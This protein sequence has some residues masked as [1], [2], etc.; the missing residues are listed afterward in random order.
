MP[1]D[2]PAAHASF[3][4]VDQAPDGDGSQRLR[5]FW[6]AGSRESGED[7]QILTS[8][9]SASPASPSAADVWRASAVAVNRHAAYKALGLWNLGNSIRRLGNPV[10]WVDAQGR[11][12]LYVVATTWLGGWAAAR[13][14]HLR[15][16]QPATVQPARAA[17]APTPAPDF[18]PVGF[19][20]LSPLFNI[21]HLVRGAP[22]DLQDGGALLPAYFEL[23]VKYPVAIRLDP[24]GNLAP[25]RS[26][27]VR[28]AGHLQA[29]QPSVAVTSSQE[30]VAYLRDGSGAQTLGVVQTKDAGQHWQN[31]TTQAAQTSA[32]VGGQHTADALINPDSSVCALSLAGAQTLLVHN[33]QRTGRHRL[34]IDASLDGRH[35]WT[36][37]ATLEDQPAFVAG[38]RF[39]EYSYPS[40][41]RVGNWLHVSYTYQ[42]RWIR[43]VVLAIEAAPPAPRAAS[44]VGAG[45]VTA[46]PRDAGVAR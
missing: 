8:T 39:N 17:S 10:A 12:H 23:G 2:T 14:L 21:S 5:A 44:G 28:M 33:P 46:L 40:C 29:L 24:Q 20:P 13:I 19:L 38:V 45:V 27:V 9:Y 41:L 37:L 32:Q 25:Q 3:L 1:L 26:A 31:L 15:E 35:D 4:S 36:R 43:H 7:V 30:A 6:F 18:E 42:K 16:V 22:V 34:V 11:T